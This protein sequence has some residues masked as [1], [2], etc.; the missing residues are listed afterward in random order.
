MGVQIVEEK[1][2]IETEIVKPDF[3]ILCS[4]FTEFKEFIDLIN[5]DEV[6]N[7]KGLKKDDNS[8]KDAKIKKALDRL[9]TEK[10]K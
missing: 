7:I 10:I 6:E 1:N 3:I 5:S 4:I 9:W 8:S 2:S